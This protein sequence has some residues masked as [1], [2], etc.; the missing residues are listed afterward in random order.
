MKIKRTYD[1]ISKDKLPKK[2]SLWKRFTCK[3]EL[4][5]N[6]LTGEMGFCRI[7]GE[8]HIVYCEKCG[9]IKGY[10]SKEYWVAIQ[11]YCDITW[12]EKLNNES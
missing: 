2:Q 4:V 10:Y 6:I 1:Y 5:D 11:E 3:H 7:S 9:H 8:E 12:K